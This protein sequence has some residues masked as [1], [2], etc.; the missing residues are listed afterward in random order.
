MPHV[1]AGASRA[2]TLSLLAGAL[3]AGAS[4][5]GL[6]SQGQL[7]DPSSL[8]TGQIVGEQRADATWPDESWWRALGDE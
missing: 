3:A 6:Q 1:P 8:S 4:T 5:H 7:L 2:L